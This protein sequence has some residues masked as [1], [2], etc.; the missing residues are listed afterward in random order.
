M[1]KVHLDT[2]EL[3]TGKDCD[4]VPFGADAPRCGVC[5]P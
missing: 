1:V 5:G 2:C 4:E 3:V